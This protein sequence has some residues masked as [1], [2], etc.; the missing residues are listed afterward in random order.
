MNIR[1]IYKATPQQIKSEA[2]RLLR[3]LL[4]RVT[5]SEVHTLT[6][7]SRTTL[8]KWSDEDRPV[9]SWGE[10][11]AAWFVLIC[12]TNPAIVKVLR[13]KVKA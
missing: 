5:L 12:G 2:D 3:E 11:D 9:S 10:R 8:Y 13:R 7:I 1:E 4:K 6:G